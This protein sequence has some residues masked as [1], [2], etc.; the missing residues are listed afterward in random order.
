MIKDVASADQRT[1]AVG[2][3]VVLN[4]LADVNKRLPSQ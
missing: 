4:W 2:I 3:N 1:A